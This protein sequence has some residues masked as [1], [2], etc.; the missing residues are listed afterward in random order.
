MMFLGA[1][2]IRLYIG[3]KSWHEIRADTRNILSGVFG[4]NTQYRQQYITVVLPI[5]TYQARQRKMGSGV[6]FDIAQYFVEEPANS[7]LLNQLVA[8]LRTFLT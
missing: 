1:G 3:H 6:N 2:K 8:V 5:S 4:I 7:K